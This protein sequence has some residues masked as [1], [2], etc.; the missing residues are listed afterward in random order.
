[1]YKVL[2]IN[3]SS[4]F[5]QKDKNLSS[6]LLYQSKNLFPIL[7]I[8]F[9]SFIHT[10]SFKSILLKNSFIKGS[11]DSPT[12]IGCTLSKSTKVIFNSG[13]LQERKPAVH[14]PAAPPPTITTSLIS[15]DDFFIY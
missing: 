12:P 2:L 6:P 8:D 9:V 10:D 7:Y 13:F 4:K 5:H 15:C 3:L 11:I 1:M 14:Q